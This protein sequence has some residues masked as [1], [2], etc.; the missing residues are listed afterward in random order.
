MQSSR[1]LPRATGPNGRAL[2]AKQPSARMHT[3]GGAQ[4]S[5]GKKTEPAWEGATS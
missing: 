3:G 2:N 5:R 1:D 4:C